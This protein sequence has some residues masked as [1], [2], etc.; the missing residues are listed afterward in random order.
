MIVP[1]WGINIC[2]VGTVLPKLGKIMTDKG[3]AV[4]A[5]CDRPV[6]FYEVNESIEMHYLAF[7]H[8][9]NV[10]CLRF[11]NS[12]PIILYEDSQGILHL[13]EN[14]SLRKLQIQRM[15]FKMQITKTLLTPHKDSIIVLLEQ[16]NLDYIDTSKTAC[17]VVGQISRSSM[18]AQSLF[19]L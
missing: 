19:Q 3:D 2:Y 16:P 8:V 4:I 5:C 7:Q 13:S 18:R 9:R 10:A 17:N 12:S 1:F 15:M 14:D 6:V 11:E